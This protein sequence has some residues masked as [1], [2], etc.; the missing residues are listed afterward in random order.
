M[1]FFKVYLFFYYLDTVE[2]TIEKTANNSNAKH[3]AGCTLNNYTEAELKAIDDLHP[4]VEYCVFGCEKGKDGVPHLQFMICF[5]ARK[6][7]STVKKLIPR[8]HWEVKSKYS[9]MLD[10]SN[11][12]KKGMRLT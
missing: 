2:K 6:K 9:T 3:W 12:C 4:L 11:Y 1:F 7:F 8:A 5:K 10:A